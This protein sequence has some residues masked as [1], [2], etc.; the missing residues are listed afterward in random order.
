MWQC[1]ERW[2]LVL[3]VA[4]PLSSP[5]PAPSCTIG[6]FHARAHV[7]VC[8]PAC[9]PKLCSP[10]PTLAKKS[11]IK[12]LSRRACT[13]RHAAFRKMNPGKSLVQDPGVAQGH[14]GWEFW[15]FRHVEHVLEG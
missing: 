7:C 10:M 1:K 5:T 2:P 6:N 11:H 8:S 12:R 4:G 15:G 3:A 13:H 9:T 14:L